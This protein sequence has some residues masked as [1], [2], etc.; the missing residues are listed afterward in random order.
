MIKVE[1][2]VA[3]V[4]ASVICRVSI[5]LD[6]QHRRYNLNLVRRSLRATVESGR[7]YLIE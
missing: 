5:D 7:V 2:T 4:R 1:Q 3:G 6:L